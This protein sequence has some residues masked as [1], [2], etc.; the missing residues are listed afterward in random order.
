M[1]KSLFDTSRADGRGMLLACLCFLHCVAGPILLSWA[2]FSSLIGVSE[3]FEPLFV[4]GSGAM[5]MI[6]FVPAYRK[7]HGRKSCLALFASGL[8]CLL[9][10][11]HVELPALSIEPVATAVG[12]S[13]IIGAHVLNLRFSKRC[14]CCDA[15]SE[16]TGEAT[17]ES[18]CATSAPQSRNQSDNVDPEVSTKAIPEG[19]I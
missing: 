14:Q 19:K 18:G 6:A 8:L 4:L 12:A 11:R 16:P 5:G 15:L 10:R 13:L 1:H 9:L 7:K 3:K 2:G 17:H